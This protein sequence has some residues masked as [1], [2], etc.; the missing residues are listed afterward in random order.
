M[1]EQLIKEEAG[2]T[3]GIIMGLHRKTAGILACVMGMASIPAMPQYENTVY[4]AEKFQDEQSM[5]WKNKGT[6]SNASMSNAIS[7]VS[8]IPQE[9]PEWYHF[10][11]LYDGKRVYSFTDRNGNIQYR[12]YGILLRGQEEEIGW[13]ACSSS[14]KLQNREMFDLEEEYWTLAPYVYQH[15][16]PTQEQRMQLRSMIK[17]KFL[18]LEKVSEYGKNEDGSRYDVWKMSSGEEEH[19]FFYGYPLNRQKGEIPKSQWYEC[20]EQGKILSVVAHPFLL[21]ARKGAVTCLEERVSHQGDSIHIYMKGRAETQRP[22]LDGIF[23]F[24]GAGWSC[25]AN[26]ANRDDWTTGHSYEKK[27]GDSYR[28]INVDYRYLIELGA[29]CSSNNGENDMT[30]T[31]QNPHAVIWDGSYKD[32]KPDYSSSK[33]MTWAESVTWKGKYDYVYDD[34][35]GGS[36][37]FELEITVK[38]P[39]PQLSGFAMQLWNGDKND[40]DPDSTGFGYESRGN[41]IF[42]GD[43]ASETIKAHVHT[44]DLV[45][46]EPG[47]ENAGSL[48]GVCSMCQKNVDEVIQP[49]GHQEGQAVSEGGYQVVRCTRCQKELSRKANTYTVTFQPEGG[50]LELTQ[51]TVTYGETYEVLPVPVKAG[52]RFDGWYTEAIGG[53]LIKADTQYTTI[54][55]QS[56]YAHW[57]KEI[58]TAIFNGNGG[59]DGKAISIGYMEKLG[60]LPDSSRL[61][62]LF[63]GWYTQKTQGEKISDQTKMPLGGADYYAQWKPITYKVHY[64]G[65][66]ASEGEMAESVFVYDEEKPLAKNQY[67]KTGYLF[68][69]WKDEKETVYEDG[70]MVSNLTAKQG[71]VLNFKAQWSPIHYSFVFHP[72]SGEGEDMGKQEHVYGT[73]LRLTPNQYTKRGY[74]FSEWSVNEDG[75]G[76][77]FIDEKTILNY[78]TQNDEEIHLYAQWKPEEYQIVF[79]H[80]GGTCQIRQ[81]KVLFDTAVGELPIPKKEH[82]KFDGWFLNGTETEF[83]CDTIYQEAQDITLTAKW[84]L[85]IKDL[86]N[87]SHI[88]PGKDGEF[89]T[90]DDE[91]YFNGSDQKPI[92]EDDEKIYSGEDGKYGTKD[93]FIDKGD[94]SHIRPGEDG[95]WGTEDDEQYDNGEDQRPGTEDDKKQEDQG[96]TNKPQGDG[97]NGSSSGNGN[98]GSG[99]SGGSS[100]NGGSSGSGN[101]SGGSVILGN[102]P[103]S[104]HSENRRGEWKQDSKGW[105]YQFADGTYPKNC[106]QYLK[107]GTQEEWYHFD[108]QGYMQI[109]WFRDVDEHWYHLHTV[110]DGTLGHMETGWFLDQDG[111]WYYLNPVSDGH[112]GAM[113][114]GWREILDSWYYFNPVSNG[115]KGAMYSGTVTPDG[116][117]V[118]EKGV[119]TGEKA[120]IGKTILTGGWN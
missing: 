100:G 70:A 38:N 9:V 119:W 49:L 21:S 74:H 42:T 58:Y 41:H 2:K 7:F 99:N 47:C 22:H 71:E 62:Y 106:W 120:N 78:T 26:V 16:E 108:E 104:I 5:V 61:G 48:K 77:T 29:Y 40:P 84:S 110:S 88:R 31:E 98:S 44:G 45:R 105:W 60:K 68:N 87:N 113:S 69:G 63:Q 93:D 102:S 10:H 19:F 24:Q 101:S 72:G 28:L 59:T 52:Y 80:N 116:Y 82:Y 81:K 50:T 117:L 107:Y 32:G 64:T 37:L 53:E 18:I 13:Y 67:K 12:I 39:I 6:A 17:E 34:V 85:H 76:D 65:N 86:G 55:N 111:L 43:I 103:S 56:L 73:S 114:I 75:T 89:G 23:L 96:S 1:E 15:E 54:G 115:T 66:Y 95:K 83:D 112:K 94:G 35:E 11:K 118:N 92:T 4:A 20:D 91:Y 109:G 3:G 46:T 57:T 30:Y 27:V 51:K 33:R 90:E 36:N 79:D 8:L 97:G 14:G 25:D